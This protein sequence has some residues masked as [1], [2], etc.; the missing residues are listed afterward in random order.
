ME[1]GG[2][3]GSWPGRPFSTSESLS[4]GRR[5]AGMF[6]WQPAWKWVPR[7]KNHYRQAGKDPPPRSRKNRRTHEGGEVGWRGQELG[8]ET[9]HSSLT[10]IL[11]T[12]PQ[13]RTAG[14]PNMVWD[15]GPFFK[16]G[17]KNLKICMVV[18][19]GPYMNRQPGRQSLGTKANKTKAPISVCWCHSVTAGNVRTHIFLGFD[20]SYWG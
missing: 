3:R 10:V 7:K 2:G 6:S 11:D 20:S 16:S 14:R 12:N 8:D 19:P 13:I 18:I 15:K 17:L 5:V 9:K 1:M 4:L